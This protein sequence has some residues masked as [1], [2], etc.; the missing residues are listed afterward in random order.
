LLRSI[1]SYKKALHANSYH[2]GAWFTL[3]CAY[4]KTNDYRS[5]IQAFSSCVQIDE[6]QGEAWANLSA[7]LQQE[8]KK[9]E[10]LATLE[11]AVKHCEG[12]W[13]MWQNLMIL[14]LE[15]KKFSKFLEAVERIVQ[16]QQKSLIDSVVF[17]KI[18][19]IMDYHIHIMK[20]GNKRTCEFYKER[21]TKLY[22]YF[23]EAMGE[24]F[25][26]WDSY[27]DYQLL[28]IKHQR[29]AADLKIEALEKEGV[30]AAQNSNE[31]KGVKFAAEATDI[32][33]R[34]KE[35]QKNLEKSEIEI[36]DK[37]GDLRLNACHC[38]MVVGWEKEK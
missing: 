20:E 6:S 31:S 14:S 30:G 32:E 18:N 23:A 12:S 3:G 24:R 21:I 16:L 4:L 11:Q 5:A 37:I 2:A 36:L 25:E 9:L 8:G 22:K 29:R 10:A 38:L 26:V 17:A 34:K 27:G 1:R 15:L 35:I 33:Q 19:Q 13:R 7:G 28:V